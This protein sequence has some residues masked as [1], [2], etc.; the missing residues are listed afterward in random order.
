MEYHKILVF[1][2]RKYRDKKRL[3]TALDEIISNLP[4]RYVMIIQGDATGADKLA[5]QYAEDRVYDCLT[6]PA[7]WH[8]YPKAA[9][10]MRNKR[11][12]VVSQPTLAV[13]FPGETGSADMEKRLRDA[14]IP[15]ILIDQDSKEPEGLF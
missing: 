12:L 5:K 15:V 7:H 9:G 13:G 4:E 2:G 6:C 8:K 11:M 1:G 10:P 3:Y 14:K